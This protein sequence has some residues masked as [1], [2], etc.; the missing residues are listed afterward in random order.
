MSPCACEPCPAPT[1]AATATTKRAGKGGSS[2]NDAR[3]TRA[4]TAQPKTAANGN[5]NGQGAGGGAARC[6]RRHGRRVARDAPCRVRPSD[7]ALV[8][9]RR[10]TVRNG[11][12]WLTE[13]PRTSL[14]ETP[15][16]TVVIAAAVAA[17]AAAVVAA[18]ADHARGCAQHGQPADGALVRAASL[19][20][21]RAHGTTWQQRPG[22]S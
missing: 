9:N 2:T 21:L 22:Q 19:A 13:N 11:T 7:R 17:A 3:D 20:Q 8:R 5:S 10:G 12:L 14:R 16:I 6:A 15:R 4:Q 1:A 18:F